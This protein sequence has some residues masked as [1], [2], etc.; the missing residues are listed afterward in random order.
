MLGLRTLQKGIIPIK[1]E[2]IARKVVVSPIQI[3][4]MDSSFTY[5]GMKHHLVLFN[6]QILG[7]KLR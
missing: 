4:E 7:G 1:N 5:L 2:V 3:I 6:F